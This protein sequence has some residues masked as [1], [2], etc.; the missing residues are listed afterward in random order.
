MDDQRIDKFCSLYVVDMQFSQ[1]LRRIF[2]EMNVERQSSLSEPRNACF[3]LIDPGEWEV[4]E[5]QI[6]SSFFLVQV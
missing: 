2:Q 5:F 1:Y 4:W 6:A 3:W